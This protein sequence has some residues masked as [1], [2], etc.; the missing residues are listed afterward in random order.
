M[1][2]PAFVRPGRPAVRQGQFDVRRHP[3]FGVPAYEA[4]RTHR[5]LS[6]YARPGAVETSGRPGLVRVIH[7]PGGPYSAGSQLDD[8]ESTCALCSG[9]RSPPRPE[10]QVATPRRSCAQ[11]ERQAECHASPHTARGGQSVVPTSDASQ[12]QRV[13]GC[14]RHGL[15]PSAE[16]GR[17]H[18]RDR[19]M[20][21]APPWAGR[22]LASI[23]DPTACPG[24]SVSL[25]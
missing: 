14:A 22:R 20:P 23:R 6:S 2:L 7:G 16:Q 21:A 18:T 1:L 3:G 8:T 19:L 9:F 5:A 25:G 24:V 4:R 12:V 15:A 11:D 10:D 13:D 17:S